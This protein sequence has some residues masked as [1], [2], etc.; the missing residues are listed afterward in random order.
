MSEKKGFLQSGA[1]KLIIVWVVLG[2]ALQVGV[3]KF[4]PDLEQDCKTWA[5]EENIPVGPGHGK[6]AEAAACIAVAHS[7]SPHASFAY[8]ML[9]LLEG[10]AGATAWNI[11]NFLIII[12]LLVHFAKE[13][14]STNMKTRREDIEK[15]LGEAK[16]AKEDAEAKFKE[17]EGRI[18]HID[19]DIEAVKA[20]MRGIGEAEK[21]RILAEAEKLS[22]RIA[23]EADFTAKQE[24]LVA[25]YKLREEAAKLAVEIAEKVIKEVINDGDRERLLD[26]YLTKVRTLS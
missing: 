4:I 5:A 25:Q 17:Y 13:P 8:A 20:E 19:R 1:F 14:L 15:A 18:A 24:L 26:E 16:K 6:H 22:A 11:P 2:V 3:N 10:M 23:T 12:T 9:P 7:E 21:Q